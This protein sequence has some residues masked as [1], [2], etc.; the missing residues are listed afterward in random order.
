M[1]LFLAT[2][3]SAT[4]ARARF[5]QVDPIGYQDDLNLYFYTHDGPRT[6]DGRTDCGK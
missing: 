2:A 5:L 1:W 3:M 4:G 6:R